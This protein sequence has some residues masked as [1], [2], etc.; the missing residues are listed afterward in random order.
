M[1]LLKNKFFVTVIAIAIALC[2]IPT[3]LYATGQ[4]DI[5]REGISFVAT[6]FRVAFNW[7]A[8]GFAGF[9]KYFSGMDRLIKENEQLRKEL[10]DYKAGAAEGEILKGENEWLREQLGFV[11][12]YRECTLQDASVIGKSATSHSVI[13]TLN[14]GSECGIEINMPIITADGVIGYVKEVGFGSCKVAALTDLSSAVGVYCPRTGI[15]GTAEGSEKYLLDG[16]FSVSGLAADCDVAIG[17]MFCTSGYGGIFPK[18]FPVGRV[19]SVTRDEFLRTVTV[20]L[21]PIADIDNATR[22][23][24]VIKVKTETNGGENAG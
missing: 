23:F 10:E 7:I 15:Y 3:V 18:N 21:E 17:D 9:G 4:R 22:V 2:M 24:A 20:E 13:L 5:L 19:V 8:D 6:P 11:A 14:R 16:H 12:E 1:K